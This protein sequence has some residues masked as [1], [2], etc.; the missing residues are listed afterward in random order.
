M[1]TQTCLE[2]VIYSNRY[3]NTSV[4]RTELGCETCRSSEKPIF[5]LSWLEFDWQSEETPIYIF[6]LFTLNAAYKMAGSC[7]WWKVEIVSSLVF[8]VSPS[9]RHIWFNFHDF[10]QEFL[11]CCRCSDA[12]ERENFG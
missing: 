2:C 1:K 12:L 4:S 3:R 11:L 10:H 8:G 5:P 9:I 7:H 6:M